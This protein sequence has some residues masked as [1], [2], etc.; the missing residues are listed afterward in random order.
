MRTL[1]LQ[2]S[3]PV[4]R[5]RFVRKLDEKT[6]E[7][8]PYDRLDHG[9]SQDRNPIAPDVKSSEAKVIKITVNVRLAGEKIIIVT[10]VQTTPSAF[11]LSPNV[12]LINIEFNIILHE[13]TVCCEKCLNFIINS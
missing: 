12:S 8:V 6:N 3:T 2:L 10:Y 1:F 4:N 9:L 11:T 5:K 7:N 13:R